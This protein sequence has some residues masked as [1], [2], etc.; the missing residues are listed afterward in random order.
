MLKKTIKKG[1]T[2][3]KKRARKTTVKL[4]PKKKKDQELDKRIQ[5][6]MNIF[7]L[8]III[9]IF[10]TSF[11]GIDSYLQFKQEQAKINLQIREAALHATFDNTNKDDRQL[12]RNNR[13]QVFFSYP[14][15]WTVYSEN[16]HLSEKSNYQYYISL[17][18][19]E[20]SERNDLNKIELLLWRGT[21]NDYIYRNRIT[22]RWLKAYEPDFTPEQHQAWQ[23][24][25]ERSYSVP[26]KIALAEKNGFTYVVK[27]SVIIEKEFNKILRSFQFDK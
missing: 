5:M 16:D 17:G 12:F 9:G 25:M 1:K 21:A 26:V 27:A 15:E 2:T 3:N 14:N 10:L 22:R 23:V 6:I 18:P 7:Y 11:I 24:F 4:A 19:D 13:Y 8:L 20:M